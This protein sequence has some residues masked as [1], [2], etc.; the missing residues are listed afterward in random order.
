MKSLVVPLADLEKGPKHVI[1]QLDQTW[2]NTALQD[3]EANARGCGEVDIV[4]TKAG[5][6]VIVRGRVTAQLSM[7]C[8]RTLEPVEIDVDTDLLLVLLPAAGDNREASRKAARKN[9]SREPQTVSHRGQKAD[10][11]Y[12]AKERE[13]SQEEAAADVYSGSEIVL[14]ALVREHII[15]ELP[16][17]PLRSDLR[18]NDKPAIPAPPVDA[19]ADTGTQI[20]PRLAPLAKVAN[21][22][23]HETKE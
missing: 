15:L 3:T 8:A 7:P 23:K 18:D 4:M 22:L 6:R 12:S 2:L 19:M 16:M 21:R 5:A 13:L 17:V 14:D 9:V 1:W 20:D 11:G 10:V